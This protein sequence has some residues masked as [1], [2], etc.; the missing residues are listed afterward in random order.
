M[1]SY[2]VIKASYDE[3]FAGIKIGWALGGEVEGFKCGYCLLGKEGFNIVDGIGFCYE[4]V[5]F[6]SQGYERYIEFTAG[7]F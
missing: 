6:Y 2:L 3:G 1:G 7:D 4:A 5:G